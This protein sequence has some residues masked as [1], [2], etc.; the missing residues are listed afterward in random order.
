[1]GLKIKLSTGL[2]ILT[3]LIFLLIVVGGMVRN[4][5]AG[6]SCPDWPLCQGHIIPQFDI[7]VFA[8]YF[9]RL[10]A[11]AVSILTL[12]I[13]VKVFFDAELRRSLGKP[14]GWALALLFSQVILGGLTVLKFLQSEIV[15]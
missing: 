5:G 12:I 8:E 14:M 1:M 4:L 9:H 6:L 11:A 15:T 13:A 2:K 10:F 7:R 3:T